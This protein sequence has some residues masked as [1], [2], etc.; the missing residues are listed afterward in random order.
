MIR[1]LIL[2]SGSAIDHNLYRRLTGLG[3]EV[4]RGRRLPAA[5]C[6]V[7]PGALR[8]HTPQTRAIGVDSHR[9]LLFGQPDGP[10]QLRGIGTRPWPAN[11]DYTVF[12]EATGTPTPRPPTKC[13]PGTPDPLRRHHDRRE[14]L[15]TTPRTPHRRPG[16]A[17]PSGRLQ[18]AP[19]R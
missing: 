9:S 7:P 5:R 10:Q 4:G 18:R 11:L 2:V 14:R 12:D 13:M 1:L 8:E 6:A 19:P 15:M 17:H 3:A 16:P